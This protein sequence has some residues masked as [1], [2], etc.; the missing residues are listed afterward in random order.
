[1]DGDP[2][3][4]AAARAAIDH[5]VPGAIVAVGSG[6]TVDHFIDELAALRGS[7][8]G[9][10]CSSGRSA[11]RLR[12]RGIAVLELNDVIAA[13]GAIPVYVDG[14]D[15]IDRSLRMIKGGG[16][17]L[18]REKIVASASARF[19]CVA[20]ESK[21]VDALGRHP[22]P[23]EVLAFARAW[24]SARL[25]AL[26]GDPRLRAG[27][28]S[29]DGNPI[30]DVAGLPLSD[31]AAVEREIDGWPGVVTCGLFARR[32]ADVALIASAEGVA[33]LERPRGRGG[34]T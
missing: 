25:R 26:G 19:V 27:F 20:D 4:R 34:P 10:V 8:P 15:E 28:V 9:A 1:V 3:K 23:V 14:A 2:L 31:P 7:F 22:L 5:L 29:D 17:A 6:S 13:G 21:R 32:G 30:L 16:G 12:D 33:R 24:V 18:T 11:A